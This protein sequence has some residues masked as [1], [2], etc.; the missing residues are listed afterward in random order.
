MTFERWQIVLEGVLLA[1]LATVT[2]SLFRFSDA[3]AITASLAVAY[4]VPRVFYTSRSWCTHTGRVVFGLLGAMMIALAVLTIWNDTVSLGLPLSEPHLVSDDGSYYRWARHYYDG[5]CPMPRTAFIG[6]PLLILATWKVLG[7]SIVWPLAL[8]VM[9]TLTTV[10]VAAAVTV[11]L[12]HDRVLQSDRWL[13]TMGLC[14]TATLMYFISQGLRI[15]KEAMIYMA[16]SLI[17]Y[18]LVGMNS[19]KKSSR[20][21]LLRDVV[22]WTVGCLILSLGRTTYLYFVAIGLAIMTVSYWRANVYKAIWL[23]VVI[24]VMFVL[25][26]MLARYSVDGHVEIVQGGYFMQKQYLGGAVQQPY[27]DMVGKYFYY[28]VW[29][30]LLILPLACSVQFIIPFPWLYNNFE[31]LS[32]FPRIAW[33]WYA[34][35]GIA[36]FYFFTMSWRR[37]MNMGTWAWWPVSIYVIIAYV[38]AGTVSRYML[39]IEPMAVPIAVFVIAKLR[40]GKMRRPFILWTLVYAVLLVVTLVVCYHIQLS[41]L[42]DLDNYYKA[43]LQN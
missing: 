31:I 25:G 36:L 32:Y 7:M 11:R 27:L 23:A 40:E 15:Q 37:G 16:I 5:S 6:F 38:I 42:Q 21:V 10:V 1:I 20:R 8:N 28:P 12:L 18:V 33:G 3:M 2:L 14:L 17:G 30:R 13:A 26:N 22:I 43:L 9:F 35:G 34:V 29:H 41:Y 24:C 39:P 19:H 4:A